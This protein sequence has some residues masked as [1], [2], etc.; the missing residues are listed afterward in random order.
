MAVVGM[1]WDTTTRGVEHPPDQAAGVHGHRQGQAQHQGDG[2]ADGGDQSW[3][4]GRWTVNEG[5]PQLP[6]L[7]CRIWAGVGRM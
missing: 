3:W 2:Q 5:L 4:R 6:Q 1:V 7:G